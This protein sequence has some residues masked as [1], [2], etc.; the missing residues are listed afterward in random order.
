P[1]YCSKPC[2]P[3][4]PTPNLCSCPCPACAELD[5]FIGTAQNAL[6]AIQN[7]WWSQQDQA[8]A[9][10]VRLLIGTAATVA[11]QQKVLDDDLW[12]KQRSSTRLA[13]ALV[14]SA[15]SGK[16]GA[17]TVPGGSNTANLQEVGGSGACGG[18]TLV[19][20]AA[21]SREIAIKAA[22]GA[23]PDS[24]DIGRNLPGIL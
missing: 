7:G 2:C 19:C 17:L 21:A 5:G 14:R 15:D 6:N 9:D 10:Q 22:L 20:T 8:T 11:S 12:N 4:C 18:N 13:A 24:F 1:S 23:R 3:T 16:Y